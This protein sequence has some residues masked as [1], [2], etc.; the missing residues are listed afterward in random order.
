[1][2]KAVRLLPPAEQE[3]FDAARYYEV[4]APGLGQ[5]FL[6]KVELTLRDLVS[7]PE[8]WPVVHDGIRRRL[9]RRF[10]YSL[11]YHIDPDELVILAIMHQ[12]QHPS[13]WLSRTR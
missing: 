8:Q 6:A 2:S 12:K 7:A 10:P 9:I 4:Q 5:N 3:L 11:L 1:M 13:Y